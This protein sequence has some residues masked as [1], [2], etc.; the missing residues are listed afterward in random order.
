MLL[1]F[2][3]DLFAVTLLH[4]YP[5]QLIYAGEGAWWRERGSLKQLSRLNF[6]QFSVWRCLV[7]VDCIVTE[8]CRVTVRA[9]KFSDGAWNIVLQRLPFPFPCLS[10]RLSCPLHS[11]W[12]R[13]VGM[14][15]CR[16]HA[17][18]KCKN[19]GCSLSLSP[20]SCV[21]RGHWIPIPSHNVLFRREGGEMRYSC[22]E[23][24]GNHGMHFW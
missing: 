14:K 5:A 24:R 22:K 11:V 19:L 9:L 17:S 2:F 13:E 16:Q 21:C 10:V 18:L 12:R 4:Y 15:G 7:A 20:F 1:W 3:R 23:G 8:M 6:A